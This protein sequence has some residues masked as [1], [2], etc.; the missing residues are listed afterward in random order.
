MPGG[1][2]VMSEWFYIKQWSNNKQY[3]WLLIDK[4]GNILLSDVNKHDAVLKSL[5]LEKQGIK[6]YV[7]NKHEQRYNDIL[8]TN[9]GKNENS[10]T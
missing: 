7:V 6:T 9:R 5:E 8:T 2:Q 1:I 3:S 4:Q 10:N